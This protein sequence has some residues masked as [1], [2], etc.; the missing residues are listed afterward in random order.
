MVGG[1]PASLVNLINADELFRKGQRD[2]WVKFWCSVAGDGLAFGSD[3]FIASPG[4]DLLKN[5]IRRR[6]RNARFIP[7]VYNHK[8]THARF[9]G[10]V[11]FV[12]VD[13]KPHLRIYA[14]QELDEIKRGSDFVAPQLIYVPNHGISNF[15]DFPSGFVHEESPAIV[16]LRHSVDANGKT[17]D[18]QV[19]SEQP[20]GHHL[21]DWLKKALPLIDFLP[22]YR[23]GHPAVSSYTYTW[24]YGQTIGW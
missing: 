20:T 12:V 10:T 5:E 13:G 16:I 7:A 8:R 9:A 19:I 3:F 18:V 14:N 21:A 23:N 1:G 4:A 11:L 15:P 2:G 22:G 17:V 24:V 6:M